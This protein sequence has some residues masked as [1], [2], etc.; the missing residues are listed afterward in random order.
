[1]Q[2]GVMTASASAVSCHDE[3]SMEPESSMTN[4]VSKYLKKSYLS[5]PVV[6]ELQKWAA[7]DGSGC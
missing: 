5:S 6:E 3:P 7:E 1:V 4:T 2:I